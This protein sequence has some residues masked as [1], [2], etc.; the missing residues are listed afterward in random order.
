MTE[1]RILSAC[2]GRDQFGRPVPVNRKIVE[3]HP[4]GDWWSAP[5][6]VVIHPYGQDGWRPGGPDEPHEHWVLQGLDA[7]RPVQACRR[8]HVGDPSPEGPMDRL[9]VDLRSLLNQHSAENASDTADFV[10]AHYLIACLEAFNYAIRYR[11]SVQG[12]DH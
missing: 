1:D 6:C 9:E 8:Q 2:G 7:P 4:L 10:L 5:D 11:E 3:R 12:H